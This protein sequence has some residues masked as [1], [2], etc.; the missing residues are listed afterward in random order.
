MTL[1]NLLELLIDVCIA[2][3]Q[4]SNFAQWKTREGYRPVAALTQ[5]HLLPKQL[6][7][8]SVKK[9]Q[10]SL[11]LVAIYLFKHVWKM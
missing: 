2:L 8:L 5:L 3:L 9:K 11:W 4:Q 7:T 10:D 1:N 6:I